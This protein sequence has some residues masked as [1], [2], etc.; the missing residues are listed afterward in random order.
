MHTTPE[1]NAPHIDATPMAKSLDE[2]STIEQLAANNPDLITVNR[3]RWIIR[4]RHNNGLAPAVK[5]LGK[6]QGFVDLFW[7]GTLLVEHKSKGKDL[8]TAFEQA[9]DYFAGI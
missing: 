6:K 7:K 3:L 2:F 1:T 5:K 8:D 4:D 9:T